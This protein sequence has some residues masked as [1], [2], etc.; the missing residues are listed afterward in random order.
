MTDW[1]C[2]SAA[3]EINH[4]RSQEPGLNRIDMKN[5]PKNAKQVNSSQKETLYVP[6][7]I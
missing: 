5:L 7:E 4:S 3:I 6:K 2:G 1:W